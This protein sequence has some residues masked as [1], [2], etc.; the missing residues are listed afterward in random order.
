MRFTLLLLLAF[1]TFPGT[2]VRAQTMDDFEDGTL[3]NPD[4]FGDTD[5]FVVTNGRLQLMADGAGESTLSVRLGGQGGEF[6]DSFALEFLVDMDFAPSASNFTTIRLTREASL[7]TVTEAAVSM[8]FGGIS[9]DQDAW[10]GVLNESDVLLGDFSGTPGALGGSPAQ[11]RFRVDYLVNRGYRFFADYS[12]GTDFQLEAEVADDTWLGLDLL[13]LTCKYTATRSDKFSFDD[14]NASYGYPA[15]E[16]PP[17]LTFATVRGPNTIEFGFNEE[18]QTTPVTDPANYQLSVAGNTVIAAELNN[19]NV[20]LTLAEPLALQEDFQLTVLEAID[21]AGNTATNLTRDLRYDPTVPVRAGNVILNEF[22]PDPNPV[23]G[24]PEQEFIELHNPS[25]TAVSLLGLEVS[26]GG[27]PITFFEE[28]RIAAG[29]Y[30]VVTDVG[31]AAAFRDLGADVIVRDLPSLS[32]A[33]DVITLAIN[34]EIIQEINYTDDWY[35]DPARDGGGYTIEYIGAG[36]AAGCRGSWKASE[37]PSG[38]TPGRENSVLGAVFDV[39]PPIITGLSV[40]ASTIEIFFDDVLN[41]D[42]FTDNSL[43]ELSDGVE[44]SAVSLSSPT[45]VVLSANLET[46][47]IY[48]LTVLPFFSDCSGNFPAGDQTFELAIPVDPAPGD[49]AINEILFNP[50]SGGNDFVELVNV[51]D[52]VFQVEGWVLTNTRSTSQTAGS[53][54]IEASRLLLPGEFLVVTADPDHLVERYLAV[55]S[56]KILDQALPSLPDDEGNISLLVNGVVIDAFDYSDE[57]HS[58]LIGDLNG[59]SLER[60]DARATT[61]DDN[62]WFSAA[63]AENF[64]TPTRGNSQGTQF[65]N[66]PDPEMTFALESQTFSPDGDG[67]EDLLFLLYETDRPGFLA[68]IR[69]FDAQGRPVRTLREV[70]LLAG[71][72]RIRWDGSTDDGQRARAGIYV[73]FV[74]LFN[75]DGEVREEKLTAVLAGNRE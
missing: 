42:E 32:N 47:R 30:V 7:G 66:F 61:Q 22:F 35:N 64:A 9:G 21:L 11:V 6:P 57:L 41:P 14:L 56:S 62:N 23:V 10:T 25:D 38:G 33:G 55:D 72:G 51:S 36:A 24:L 69:I 74:E 65:V 31:A 50:A 28:N 4:W 17:A 29:G 16:T 43:F 8:Q 39:S 54:T 71:A 18:V 20:T 12:G 40:S 45:S 75:P 13:V 68:R 73:L 3:E 67:F 63:Q 44:I 27:A 60:I 49:V 46:G 70:E 15:D 1:I 37:D 5:D 34:G 19:R 53:R 52:K 26:S 48:T 58:P 2:G 59:V